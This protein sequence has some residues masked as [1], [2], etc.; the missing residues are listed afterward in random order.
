MRENEYQA[1]LIRIL[2]LSELSR[3][4]SYGYGIAKDVSLHSEGDLRVK[5]ESL[6][7]VLHRMEQEGLITA[8]WIH[9]EGRPRKMYS[10]TAKGR[11][12]WEHS[13][14]QF[15]AQSQ[16]AL[17]VIAFKPARSEP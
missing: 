8:Q 7:P 17:K 1:G 5:P 2:V 10:M 13:R 16:G 4:E 12:R 6:Y 11:R 3:G 9:A 14:K 15:M